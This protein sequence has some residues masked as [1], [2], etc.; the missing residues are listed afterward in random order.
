MRGFLGHCMKK[1]LISLTMFTLLLGIGSSVGASTNTDQQINIPVNT[2]IRGDVGS[3]HTLSEQSI[4]QD[5][6]GMTCSVD[7][8]AENQRSVHPG[9]NIVVSSGE[10]TVTLENVER[11]ANGITKATG[12]LILSNTLK[13]TLILGEDKV[14]S[15]GLTVNLHCEEPP[16]EIEVCRDGKVITIKELDRKDS[17][18]QAPCPEPKTPEEPNVLTTATVLPNTGAGT[19]IA[20]ASVL[21]GILGTASHAVITRK[22]LQ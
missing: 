18:T 6:I 15:G 9:N 11:E 5:L 13:V 3:S 19:G 10:Q 1:L 16:K 7:A 12:K 2:V 4:E 14:F 8:T 20:I 21:S 17:D 22:K